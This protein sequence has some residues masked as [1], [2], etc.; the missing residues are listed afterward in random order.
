MIKTIEDTPFSAEKGVSSIVLREGSVFPDSLKN[1]LSNSVIL[2]S[3]GEHIW[4][5]NR[6]VIL[7]GIR[8]ARG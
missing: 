2:N 3:G 6:R 1:N 7:S 5:V 4:A 8:E